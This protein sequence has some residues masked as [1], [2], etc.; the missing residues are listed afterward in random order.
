MKIPKEAQRQARML[1]RACFTDGA[2]DDEKVRSV[3]Q[4]LTTTRP[5][6][7]LAIAT[8][9]ARLVRLEIERCTAHVESATPIHSTLART[10]REDLRRNYE[11]LRDIRF[12]TNP[13][14]VGGLH[15]RVG[16][17]VWDG[18]VKRQLRVLEEALALGSEDTYGQSITRN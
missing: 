6:H 18:S 10:V 17:H 16:S 4:R 11:G 5:R 2:L 3:M 1:F 9:F 13:Q 8:T 15:I 14:L 7:T 12:S